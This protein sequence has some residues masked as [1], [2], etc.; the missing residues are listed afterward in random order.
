MYILCSFDFLV[1]ENRSRSQQHWT[2]QQLQSDDKCLLGIHSILGSRNVLIENE[3][4]L[5]FDIFGSIGNLCN[6]A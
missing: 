5:W 1:F 4:F 6:K 3:L 2:R